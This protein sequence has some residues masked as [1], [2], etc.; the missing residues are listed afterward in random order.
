MARGGAAEGSVNI[1]TLDIAIVLPMMVVWGIV[2]VIVMMKLQQRVFDK[3][4]EEQRAK[5]LATGYFSGP[6]D[7]WSFE[8]KQRER[9]AF[10]ALYRE[11][12]PGSKLIEFQW[13]WLI[14]GLV[15]FLLVMATLRVKQGW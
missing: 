5:Y 7:W 8:F 11:F 3:L 12:Y 15:V 1:P 10:V 13:A 14:G 2:N 9:R 4:S 6:R